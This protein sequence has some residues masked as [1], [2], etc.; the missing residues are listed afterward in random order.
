MFESPVLL[1]KSLAVRPQAA[2]ALSEA[3]QVL[4]AAHAEALVRR[5]AGLIEQHRE[6]SDS[7]ASLQLRPPV[8]RQ[9]AAGSTVRRPCNVLL[10]GSC[11]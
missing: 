1:A 6:L 9:V 2:M 7:C 8:S 10:P 5:I 4:L 11:A 3:Q